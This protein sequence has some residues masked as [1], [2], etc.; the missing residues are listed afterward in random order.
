MHARWSEPAL[1]ALVDAVQGLQFERAVQL[2]R[3]LPKG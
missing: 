3:E 1:T 2:L